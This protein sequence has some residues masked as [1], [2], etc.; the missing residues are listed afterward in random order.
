M[1]P[2]RTHFA[3]VVCSVIAGIAIRGS[4]AA[5]CRMNHHGRFVANPGRP[6]PFRS[7]LLATFSAPRRWA[8]QDKVQA[9]I[10]ICAQSVL[11]AATLAVQGRADV[12][13]PTGQSRPISGYFITVA[14][15]GERK[16][17]ADR[18]RSGRFRGTSRTFAN[19]T[20]QSCRAI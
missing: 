2:I 4:A 7:A 20:T 8:I 1:S 13:L 3:R 18:R 15:S 17:S 6:M 19:A 14:G 10:A 9:P 11:A 12:Q 5:K 16:T